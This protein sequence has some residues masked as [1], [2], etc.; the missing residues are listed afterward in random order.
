MT[1]ERYHLLLH[2]LLD[3]L[4]SPRLQHAMSMHEDECENNCTHDR[5]EM[6]TILDDLAN[7]DDDVNPPDGFRASWRQEL[8]KERRTIKPAAPRAFRPWLAIACVV[9]FILSGTFMLRAG[10]IPH[11]P[12]TTP[13]PVV[14]TGGT[15]TNPQET[16]TVDPNAYL[17]GLKIV[18][19]GNY[20]L[21]PRDFDKDV[22]AI[23]AY[24]DELEGY[25]AERVITG[26]PPQSTSDKGRQA[27]VSLRVP[28]SRLDQFL[29]NLTEYG[30][31]VS[32]SITAND[33]T[34]QYNEYVRQLS[35]YE[36][37]L[38]S[39]TGRLSTSTDLT[40][41]TI[42]ETAI[43]DLTARIDTVRAKLANWDA[44]VIFAQVEVT[45]TESP[46]LISANMG[47]GAQLGTQ[48]T[49]SLNAVSVFVRDILSFLVIASP[50]LAIAAILAALAL[51]VEKLHW[52]MK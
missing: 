1:C 50:W 3:G 49:M 14:T 35:Q 20:Q 51:I 12:F 37:Q 30:V 2:D 10:I 11:Q 23:L 6:Q 18:R 29:S 9:V 7:L 16:P 43:I 8:K 21:I 28:A 5:E 47:L 48:F 45:F 15:N 41:A 26:E 32:S 13:D 22:S 27:V 42:L 33:M 46:A 19:S 34:D 4:L 24:I 31:H 25:V 36:D 44:M 40:E 17:A 52:R 39:L 38:K